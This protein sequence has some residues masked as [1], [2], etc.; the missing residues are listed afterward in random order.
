MIYSKKEIMAAAK[1]KINKA[2]GRKN[3]Y[4][5]VL[6]PIGVY[7]MWQKQGGRCALTNFELSLTEGKYRGKC[8]RP[9]GQNFNEFGFAIDR[10]DSDKA[11]TYDNVH[12]VIN[13]VNQMKGS[14]DQK[15]FQ[16]ISAATYATAMG[17]TRNKKLFDDLKEGYEKTQ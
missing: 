17:L 14:Y 6:T 13:A 16:A 7:K 11:Y 9:T 5:N 15:F 3:P 4:R 8:K 1:K 2:K 12:L 10:E